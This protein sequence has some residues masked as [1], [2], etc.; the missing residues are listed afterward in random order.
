[1]RSMVAGHA[2]ASIR[3]A[4]MVSLRRSRPC[5]TAAGRHH[6]RGSGH[7]PDIDDIRWTTVTLALSSHA[8]GGLTE[9]DFQFAAPHPGTRPT[10]PV[11]LT[12]Q[13]LAMSR[14]RE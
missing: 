7:H 10:C 12:D 5:C 2:L 3:H 8:E 1:M 6:G 14:V 11:R 9:R 13:R 4:P